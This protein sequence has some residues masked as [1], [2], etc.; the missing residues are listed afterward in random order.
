MPSKRR[1]CICNQVGNLIIQSKLKAKMN[2]FQIKPRNRNR[3]QLTV[4][5]FSITKPWTVNRKTAFF[6]FLF[7]L[8]KNYNSKERRKI[9]LLTTFIILCKKHFRIW[10]GE[11]YQI[12]PASPFS[13][14]A[15]DWLPLNKFFIKKTSK[16]I[17][18][19]YFY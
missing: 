19:T 17:L 12:N 4:K 15:T 18:V 14:I 11:L 2:S 8:C 6:F 9:S 7:V 10:S 16:S 13:F 5:V 1:I 3:K